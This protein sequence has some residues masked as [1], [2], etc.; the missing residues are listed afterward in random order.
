[1][2]TEQKDLKQNLGTSVLWLC[3]Q[4]SEKSIF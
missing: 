2:K 4:F 3:T 1:M